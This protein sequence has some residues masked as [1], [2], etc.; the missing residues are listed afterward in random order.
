MR[1]VF[2]VLI[3]V[4]VLCL[5]TPGW[6]TTFNPATAADLRTAL[7]SATC[8][9]TINLT[10][11]ATYDATTLSGNKWFVLSNTSDCGS[12]ITIT[13]TNAASLPTSL[14]LL[15]PGNTQPSTAQAAV[16][17]SAAPN[18]GI[19]VAD[20][21]VFRGDAGAKWYQLIGLDIHNKTS[22]LFTPVLIAW[23]IYGSAPGG[24]ATYAEIFDTKH[25]VI[26]RC[27]IHPSQITTS[28]VTTTNPL[29]SAAIGVFM[30]G[31]DITIKNSYIA[32]FAGIQAP[33]VTTTGNVTNTS[34]VIAGMG[35]T[36]GMQTSDY[37]YGTGIPAG[38]QLASIDSGTQVTMT[39][40]ATA[41]NSGVS[42]T[43]GTVTNSYG[44]AMGRGGQTISLTQNY[45]EAWFN[46]VF[47]GGSQ[48][49]SQ[50]A[51]N[52]SA[53][54]TTT[55]TVASTTGLSVN[56]FFSARVP[57]ANCQASPPSPAGQ[58]PPCWRVGQVTTISGSV[59]TFATGIGW[60]GFDGTT[61]PCTGTAQSGCTVFNGQTGEAVWNAAQISSV[62]IT[63]N[64]FVKR[65]AW[66]QTIQ[67]GGCKG[68]IEVKQV[69]GLT[70]DGNIFTGVGCG[71]L[72]IEQHQAGVVAPNNNI[73]NVTFSNNLLQ[74][75]G[76]IFSLLNDSEQTTDYGCCITVNNNLFVK[77]TVSSGTGLSWVFPTDYTGSWFIT[78]GGGTAASV[79][80][81][82]NTVRDPST[83]ALHSSSGCIANPCV[84]R[85]QNLGQAITL[86]DNIFDE[87]NAGYNANN[88]VPGGAT[89]Q[90]HAA[91]PTSGPV[92]N[93]NVVI[94]RLGTGDP[95]SLFTN[96]TRVST[97]AAVGF[98]NITTC[99][100]QPTGDNQTFPDYS[101]CALASNSPF[102]N[103][104]SDGTDPGVNMTALNVALGVVTLPTGSF[105]HH[106]IR[107]R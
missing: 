34:A 49:P 92:D 46:G 10:A 89:E 97:D 84:I 66:A 94:D 6:A 106:R 105:K 23:G 73:T 82:H 72:L 98:V 3:F 26:D 58:N 75:A 30:D 15:D 18:F 17:S 12:Y 1:Q 88:T 60:S 54:T 39:K 102:H 61:A 90:L 67:P 93:K 50:Y 104:A 45:I 71:S 38:T 43:E 80:V 86:Q 83:N 69:V 51:V 35:T 96:S 25:F 31:V 76:P 64:T 107:R 55:I 36:T 81:K 87:G 53:S 101:R 63:R 103:A 65:Y 16:L 5:A 28:A 62:T 37:I 95:N 24:A 99:D 11:G 19:V 85:N 48:S 41:T 74:G 57:D 79:L 20:D 40:N 70:V 44:I 29:Q 59:V 2:I 100:A 4:N 9:D 42:L 68:Y 7:L 91:W 13:S 52:V 8:G 77:P 21:N 56:M 33:G 78:Y 32:G 14:R 47:L 27:F 22:T